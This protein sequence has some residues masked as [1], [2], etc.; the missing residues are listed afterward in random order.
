M[1]GRPLLSWRVLLLPYLDEEKLFREFKLDQPWDSEHN[2]KLL[3]RMP[4]VFRAP[5]GKTR[6]PHATYFQ[7]FTGKNA[8]FDGN[9]GARIAEITDGTSNTILIIEAGEAVPWTKPADL[10]Y[11]A[12]KPL[13]RLGG[14]FP[15]GFHFALGDGAVRFCKSRFN[16]RVLRAMITRNGGEPIVDKLDD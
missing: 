3:P 16:E 12:K 5:R 13:P 9:R 1:D 8:V 6:E 15:E 14:I 4:D 7:V 10:V 2:K 11:D